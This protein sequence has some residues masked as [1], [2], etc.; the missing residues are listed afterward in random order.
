VSYAKWKYK[1]EAVGL[2]DLTQYLNEQE[3]NGNE[4]FAVVPRDQDL[5][6]VVSRKSTRQVST[7]SHLRD[8]HLRG[9]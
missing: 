8:S 2:A 5:V 9:I 3:E 1:A 7:Y 4:I 6:I